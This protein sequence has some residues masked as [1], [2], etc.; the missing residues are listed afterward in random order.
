[1][2]LR[3]AAT[4]GQEAVTSP[5]ESPGSMDYFDDEPLESETK[6]E[7]PSHISLP[8][9]NDQVDPPPKALLLP[10]SLQWRWCVTLA[11]GFRNHSNTVSCGAGLGS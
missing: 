2:D 7:K 5:Q 1:M 6:G 9:L 4:R 10:E 3:D 11:A 8:S